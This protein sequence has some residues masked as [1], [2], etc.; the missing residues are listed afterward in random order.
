MIR[1]VSRYPLMTVRV[2]CVCLGNICRSPIAEGILRRQAVECGLELE[3]D[4]AG[5][6]DWHV[7]DH[8][9]P[10]AIR[11]GEAC[12]CQMTMV[13]RQVRSSDFEEFD[14]ILAMDHSNLQNLYRWPES[15]PE[16]VH[17]IRSFD[18]SAS[19][20][21]VP[22]PYYGTY[23]DFEEVVDMLESACRGFLR[24]IAAQ[25]PEDY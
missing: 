20:T 23:A 13:A 4:S 8:P 16:K 21:E 19:S 17:L 14:W 6:G 11:A 10:R 3:I 15:K 1:V 2:L 22:D 12:G 5:T 24:H 7:G 18:L 25:P 9:D